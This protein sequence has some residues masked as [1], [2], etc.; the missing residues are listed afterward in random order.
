MAT[1]DLTPLVRLGYNA[2]I[3]SMKRQ[4]RRRLLTLWRRPR[5]SIT[6]TMGG[7][8]PVTNQQVKISQLER[9]ANAFERSP[10]LGNFSPAW[11]VLFGMQSRETG[12]TCALK[13]RGSDFADP[14]A[15]NGPYDR[16][17]RVGL[18]SSGNTVVILGRC[19]VTGEG[20]ISCNGIRA[21]FTPLGALVTHDQ[22]SLTSTFSPQEFRAYHQCPG[23]PP[24]V[25]APPCD[26]GEWSR[27]C[28]AIFWAY[29]DYY[30][31]LGIRE[32]IGF[33]ILPLDSEVVLH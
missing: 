17:L 19:T 28:Q 30:R 33:E 6:I 31:A 29:G 4:K 8:D 24:S 16:M 14:P 20:A 15:H 3:E 21:E 2:I 10:D 7:T 26:I 27:H 25:T 13:I 9:I 5:A 32:G 11:T 12:D 1:I 22:I 23:C 18:C